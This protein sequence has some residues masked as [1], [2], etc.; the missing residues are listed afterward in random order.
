M[1]LFPKE[2]LPIACVCILDPYFPR[3]QISK[4]TASFSGKWADSLQ[5]SVFAL[6]EKFL[7]A[8]Q[9]Y[10][11]IPPRKTA[12]SASCLVPLRDRAK[13]LGPFCGSS[14][15]ASQ[16]WAFTTFQAVVLLS[17]RESAIWQPQYIFFA[18]KRVSNSCLVSSLRRIE[19]MMAKWYSS[20]VFHHRN[21]KNSVASGPWWSWPNQVVVYVSCSLSEQGLPETWF[22]FLVWR[23]ASTSVLRAQHGF[24][25]RVGDP[26]TFLASGHLQ[27]FPEGRIHMESLIPSE[28]WIDPLLTAG[29]RKS[30][31]FSRKFHLLPVTSLAGFTFFF[32]G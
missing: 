4:I 3:K 6:R 19:I 10:T 26:F 16:G 11:I 28:V 5:V 30:P 20:C 23:Q 29:V 2:M 1:F 27:L 21:V 9:T 8:S 24:E 12:G 14:P 7:C 22:S 32:L 31:L 15:T 17:A 18:P 13:D 25:C